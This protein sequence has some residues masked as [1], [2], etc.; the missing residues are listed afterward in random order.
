MLSEVR[1]V[2]IDE[3]GEIYFEFE[4]PEIDSPADF[5]ECFED[6]LRAVVEIG[7][8]V[9]SGQIACRL[10]TGNVV[11]IEGTDIC[12]LSAMVERVRRH[13]RVFSW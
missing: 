2:L 13:G 11:W 10:T 12:S 8:E 4:D 6:L 1:S 3:T 5:E 9:P 7:Q